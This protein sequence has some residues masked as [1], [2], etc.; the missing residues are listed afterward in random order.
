[1]NITD[2]IEL[3]N[4]T[5]EETFPEKRFNQL[6]LIRKLIPP[7]YDSLVDSFIDIKLAKINDDPNAI[8]VIL[9]HGIQT[10]GH[11]QKLGSVDVSHR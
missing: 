8:V 6:K 3:L 5:W 10:D 7:E 4:N 1:M 11:W 9:I 2:V